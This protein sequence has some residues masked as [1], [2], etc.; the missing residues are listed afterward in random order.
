[1]PTRAANPRMER[2]GPRLDRS[3]LKART[4]LA[5]GGTIAGMGCAVAVAVL[6]VP[7]LGGDAQPMEPVGAPA[8]QTPEPGEGVI[9]LPA[10]DI[11]GIVF[12]LSMLPE[13]PRVPEPVE[14][15][16]PIVANNT[17]EDQPAQT[18]ATKREIRYLGSMIGSS[19]R[20]AV[21][22]IDGEQRLVAEG[23][24][25][26][27]VEIVEVTRELVKL[28]VDG[29]PME[30]ERAPKTGSRITRV[31]DAPGGLPSGSALDRETQAELRRGARGSRGARE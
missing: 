30:L 25:R 5:Q 29:V 26:D 4:R 14:I 21:M 18:P 12:R 27:G 19:R 28:K 1:M 3:S 24:E 23:G 22:S 20:V 13:A 11:E 31:G 7:S 9:V 16:E 17:S 10:A 6:G 2:I 15:D 8:V